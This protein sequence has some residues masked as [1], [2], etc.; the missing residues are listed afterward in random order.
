MVAYVFFRREVA[1]PCYEAMKEEASRQAYN[2]GLSVDRDLWWGDYGGDEI[3][4]AFAKGEKGIEA[5]RIFLFN[6]KHLV[7]RVD[8]TGELTPIPA[9]EA[10]DNP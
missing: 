8:W 3:F 1:I 10:P 9:A 5:A 4:F 7:C 2:H 6:F